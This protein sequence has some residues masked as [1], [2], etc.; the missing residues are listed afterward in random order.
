M[1]LSS[2]NGVGKTNHLLTS[3]IKIN[4][5]WIKDLNVRP[6]T[7][8]IIEENISSMLFD[9]GLTL[10]II[11]IFGLYPQARATKAKI[12][13][14]TCIILKALC[15]VELLG[16]WKDNLLNGKSYL[17]MICLIRG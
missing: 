12:N 10:I 15:T 2:V 13:K 8:R 3:Q 16:R 11:I 6:E 1:T 17:Q 9:I 4:S 5:K 14:C 7:I